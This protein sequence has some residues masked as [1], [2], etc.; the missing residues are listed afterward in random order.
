M[1]LENLDLGFLFSTLQQVNGIRHSLNEMGILGKRKKQNYNYGPHGH[2]Q[3]QGQ[4][5]GRFSLS[6]ILNP[7]SRTSEQYEASQRKPSSF[8]FA[9]RQD[10][11]QIPA[12][13]KRDANV[14]RRGLRR[15]QQQQFSNRRR[16]F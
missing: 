2:G 12:R 3:E 16:L 1:K 5:Q 10:Y 9:R 15:G 7:T 14:T 13:G 6:N 11:H 4:K 8:L